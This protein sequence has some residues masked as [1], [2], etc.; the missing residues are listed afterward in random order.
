MDWGVDLEIIPVERIREVDVA[1]QRGHV[2]LQVTTPAG[3]RAY[4]FPGELAAEARVMGDLAARFTPGCSR[5]LPRRLYGA[6]AMAFDVEPIRPFG[7]AVEAD[8]IL[9]DARATGPVRAFLYSPRRQGQKQ[10]AALV[11][12]DTTV[13]IIGPAGSRS[14]ALGDTDAITV[15]LSPLIGHVGFGRGFGLAYPAPLVA[16]GATFVRQARRALADIA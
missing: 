16:Q 4:R 9:A 15:A 6:E 1:A 13:E 11:L 3:S 7:Q 12:R 2:R 8:A 5:G 14:H 10:G